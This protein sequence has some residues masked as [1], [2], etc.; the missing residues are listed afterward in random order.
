MDNPLLYTV[1]NNDIDTLIDPK[2]LQTRITELAKDI[3]R[4][5]QNQDL[6]MVCILRGG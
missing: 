4:D 5:Y 1:T 2:T 6:L 3:T